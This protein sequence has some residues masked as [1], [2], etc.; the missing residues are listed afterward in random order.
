MTELIACTE[1]V[2]TCRSRGLAIC[3][4]GCDTYHPATT[5][6]PATTQIVDTSGLSFFFVSCNNTEVCVF[7]RRKASHPRRTAVVVGRLHPSRTDFWID[8][9]ALVS[10]RTRTECG[11]ELCD[12][13]ACAVF[14]GAGCAGWLTGISSAVG[15]PE[16]TCTTAAVWRLIRTGL[17]QTSHQFTV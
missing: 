15:V 7:V 14:S 17:W 6:V 1:L 5:G 11:V 10:N 13:R 9:I 3:A 2:T 16:V 4:D 8:R 12:V